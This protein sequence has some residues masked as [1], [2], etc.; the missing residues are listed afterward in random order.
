MRRKP[1]RP[2]QKGQVRARCRDRCWRCLRRRCQRGCSGRSHGADPA[3]AEA[4]GLPDPGAICAGEVRAAHGS[5]VNSFEGNA[6]VLGSVFNA[7]HSTPLVDLVCTRQRTKC[8]RWCRCSGRPCLWGSRVHPTPAE[9]ARLCCSQHTVLIMAYVTAGIHH[10][11]AERTGLSFAE[12]P[13]I[14]IGANMVRTNRGHKRRRNRSRR[15][16]SVD[17]TTTK[18]AG[19]LCREPAVQIIEL[20]EAEGRILREVR[21]GV[22]R[23]YEMPDSTVIHDV[24]ETAI[25]GECVRGWRGNVRVR[26]DSRIAGR[27]REVLHGPIQ[28]HITFPRTAANQV[29]CTCR[30]LRECDDTAHTQCAVPPDLCEPLRIYDD[31]KLC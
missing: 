29:P 5:R 1:G 18:A 14:P 16:L 8:D 10:T 27:K 24:V 15:H 31:H 11:A 7:P 28:V 21:T 25:G 13:R 12:V 26:R 4:A 9:A 3:K 6:C 19:L 22:D 20:F 30:H 2:I 23:T 17:T